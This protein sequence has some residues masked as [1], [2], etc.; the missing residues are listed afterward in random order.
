MILYIENPKDANRKLLELINKFG[1]V[2]GHKINIQKLVAFLYTNNEKSE[3]EIKKTIPFTI[4]LK[5]I[6]YLGINLPKEAKDLYSE[7][8]KIL[9]KEIKDDTNRWKDIPCS[10]IGR[11]N[12][13]KVTIQPKAIYRFNAIPIKLPVAFFTELEQKFLQFVWKHK[14]PQI[15]KVILRKKNGAG[16]IRLPD[17]RLYYK[18]TVIK[19]VWYWYKNRN[20]DQWTRI[21]SSEINPHTYGHLTYDKGGKNIQWRKDSLF[22]RPREWT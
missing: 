8:Y 3:K 5:R 11:I 10:W 20:I 17:F 2:A 19:T 13:V 9:M 7:N 1:K 12:N 16:G 14:R 21:E 4:T 22:C 18:A 6:K 15:A